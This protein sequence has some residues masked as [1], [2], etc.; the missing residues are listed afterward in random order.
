MARTILAVDDNPADLSRI[1]KL[2]SNAG[3]TWLSHGTATETPTTREDRGMPPTSWLPS[4]G[5]TIG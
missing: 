1:E 4:W 5:P 3:A 2:L